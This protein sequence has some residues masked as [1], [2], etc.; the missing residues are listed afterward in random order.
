MKILIN[1]PFQVNDGLKEVIEEKV[2]K[3]TNFFERITETEVFLKIGDKRHR[4]R[5]QIVELRIAVPGQTLFAEQRSDAV[6]K[7]VAAA[8]EKARKQLLKYKAQTQSPN[9]VN[10]K[11]D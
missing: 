1:A 9:H 11:P 2:G 4:H 8:T 7:A 5:E 6:E 3:L 10:I